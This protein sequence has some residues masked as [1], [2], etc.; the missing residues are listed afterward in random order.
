MARTETME[1]QGLWQPGGTEEDSRF[2]DGNRHVRLAYE[3]EEEEEEALYIR[4]KP[5]SKRF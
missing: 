1:G 3:E 5:F 4:G 2:C